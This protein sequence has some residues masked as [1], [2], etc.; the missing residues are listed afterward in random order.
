[1]VWGRA[2]YDAGVALDTAA[3]ASHHVP[4]AGAPGRCDGQGLTS[5]AQ[6]PG[7]PRSLDDAPARLLLTVGRWARVRFRAFVTSS[8]L[9]RQPPTRCVESP[10]SSTP[11][12]PST[13]A[14]RIAI[15]GSG[16][17]G[18]STLWTL[19]DTPHE[20]HLFEAADRLG[21]HTNTVTWT[22]NGCH[23]PV[24]TGFIVLN[25]ATYR[26]SSPPN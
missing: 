21:G 15:V 3:A 26:P 24:D 14:K 9:P 20:I 18:L 4:A 8:P 11:M 22:H 16:V 6:T 2:R 19:R 7:P 12:P 13:P 25:V 17:A 23:S 10:F 1:V 5:L